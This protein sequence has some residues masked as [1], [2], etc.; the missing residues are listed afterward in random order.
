MLAIPLQTSCATMCPPKLDA[1]S[2]QE[3]DIWFME[4]PGEEIGLVFL[5]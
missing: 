5:G 2:R 1:C 3:I 4:V